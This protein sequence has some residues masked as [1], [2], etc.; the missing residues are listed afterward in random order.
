MITV[1]TSTII[2]AP[3]DDVWAMIRDFNS[4]VEWHPAIA[5]SHIEDGKPGDAVGAVRSFSLT[6]GESL[7]EQL[8]GLSDTTYAF[9]YRILTSDVPLLKY[10]AH[11]V[12][13]PVTASARTYWR[14]WSSFETPPGQEEQLSRVVQE[15]VYHAGFDAVAERL[16]AGSYKSAK[17]RSVDQLA[18]QSVPHGGTRQSAPPKHALKAGFNLLLWGTR[19][20]THELK[21]CE[22]LAAMG[23]DGVEVPI[24]EGATSEYAG[25][26]RR[27]QDMGLK[28]TSVAIV[29]NGDTLSDDF[30]MRQKAID[31][32]KYVADCSSALGAEVLAGPLTQPLA[33]F[34]G[35]GPTE[36][37]WARLVEASR[38]LA[39]HCRGSGLKVAVEPL[40]RFEC[41]ALNTASQAADLVNAVDMP[42]Y[43]YLFDS[44][45]ANIEE[46]APWEALRRH[47]AQMTHVHVSENDRGTPGAGHIDFAAM[48]EVLREIDWSG[49]VTVEAFGQALPDIA[50]ATKVWRPLFED[51]DQ[52]AKDALKFLRNTWNA[53]GRTAMEH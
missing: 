22:G 44:F 12:L 33:K 14:W 7:R 52:L 35:K 36:T 6:G 26:G 47:A 46:K 20:G 48:F 1:D 34:S 28:R 27:L 49:W 11:V 13:K 38:A 30:E 45:H 3:I 25:L 42:H 5:S 41:Y 23:W 10:H 19:T 32:L 43:G 51:E 16:G 9:S 50:A 31:H 2:D 37:E 21:R 24:F 4:H 18:A 8:T 53:A 15:D 17:R 29:S 39:T 40:N